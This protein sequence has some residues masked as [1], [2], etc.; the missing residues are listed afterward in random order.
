MRALHDL[1]TVADLIRKPRRVAHDHPNRL[2]ALQEAP[3]HFAPDLT[4][5]RGNNDHGILRN[6]QL[7]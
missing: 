1:D 4:G 5:G 3:Q 6:I 2:A 7:K